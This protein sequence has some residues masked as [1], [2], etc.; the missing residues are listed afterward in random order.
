MLKISDFISGNNN[1]DISKDLRVYFENEIRRRFKYQIIKLN[2][3]KKKVKDIVLQL[4]EES[5]INEEMKS[6]ILNY[7]R[8]LNPE[9]H[10]YTDITSD[11][12]RRNAEEILNFIFTKL[13]AENNVVV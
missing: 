4:R 10:I 13:R 8:M 5:V 9:H 1:D 6:E 11:E 3:E 12:W 7:L 2:I